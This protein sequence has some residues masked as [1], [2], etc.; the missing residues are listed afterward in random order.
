MTTAL[1][2]HPGAHTTSVSELLG[3][4]TLDGYALAPIVAGSLVYALGTIRLWRMVGIGHGVRR[5]EVLAYGLG[6]VSLALALVSPLDFLSDLS[7]AAHMSQHEILMLV[8]APLV[9]LG[10]PWVPLLFA[11]P[12]RTRLRIVP[13]LRTRA[14]I[15]TVRVLLHPV[16]VLFLHAIVLWA[17]HLPSLFEGAMRD[18]RVHAVQHLTFFVTAAAFWWAIVYGRFGPSGYGVGILFVFATAAH[19]SLLGVLIL[20]AKQVVYRIYTD[21]TAAVGLDALA[22]Q[23]AAGL[24][25]WVPAGVVLLFAALAICAAWLGEARRRVEQAE[26]KAPVAVRENAAGRR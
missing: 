19:T 20:F 21:R 6:L 11:L 13:V 16:S 12:A 2:A 1:S 8:S 18:E 15:R 26:L 17:W 24:I 4:W 25:M 14:W 3:H 10:R 23:Q 5:I 7:F 22:D 9:V